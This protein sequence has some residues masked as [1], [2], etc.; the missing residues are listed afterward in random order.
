MNASLEAESKA[1]FASIDRL[2]GDRAAHYLQKITEQV[3]STSLMLFDEHSGDLQW[4]ERMF[5]QQNAALRRLEQRIS[6][7]VHLCV[8]SAALIDRQDFFSR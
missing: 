4:Q 6:G 2:A 7:M 3:L 8:E 5:L 1:Q